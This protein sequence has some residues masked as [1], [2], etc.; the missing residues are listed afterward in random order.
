[1][2]TIIDSLIVTLSLDPKGFDDSQKRATESL[3][4]MERVARAAQ[5]PLNDLGQQARRTGTSVAAGAT[6]GTTALKNLAIAGGEA[7]TALKTVEGVIGSIAQATE[8]GAAV[9]RAAWMIGL[10]GGTRQLDALIQAVEETA[11]VP[12]GT[13]LNLL[14][15]YQQRIA[16]NKRTGQWSPEFQEL[17]RLG[18]NFSSPVLDQIK[19]IRSALKNKPGPETE[20]WVNAVGLGPWLNFLKLSQGQADSAQNRAS[21]HSLTGD[22]GKELEKAQTAA[23]RFENSMVHLWETLTAHFSKNGFSDALEGWSLFIDKLV[24][25]EN[26]V[27]SLSE[28]L[29]RS[30]LQIINMVGS[31]SSETK[32][33]NQDD[34]YN[35]LPYSHIPF[36]YNWFK[37]RA[38]LWGLIG[39]KS[40]N[41]SIVTPGVVRA[42]TE[43]GPNGP[44]GIPDNA[45]PG[46][47]PAMWAAFRF[48]SRSE[49]ATDNPW[50]Y[51]HKTGDPKYNASGYTQMLRANWKKYA[52]PEDAAKWNNAIEAPVDAQFRAFSK[53]FAAEGPRPW[54]PNAGGSLSSD[55][56]QGLESAMS[57]ARSSRASLSVIRGANAASAGGVTHN[58]DIDAN[59]AH[60]TVNTQATDAYGIGGA[61]SGTIKDTIRKNQ[62]INSANTGLE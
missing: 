47:D 59:I 14:N 5:T 44:G 48:I 9:S 10:P 28:A 16:E 32:A 4:Q 8:R 39:N 53:M 40:E 35:Q 62:L 17:G 25:G 52:D 33:S 7:F 22:Q 29:A 26:V 51:M 34:L 43:Y 61:I 30:A 49:G 31:N 46:A 27:N 19:Q 12:Q 38:H 56:V 54:M 6:I 1:M 13:S 41:N 50:N 57:A 20:A 3:R 18:V 45:P 24:N 60:I 11:H 37:R 15:S 42:G 55:R 58:N 2:A 23:V 36:T 21:Q